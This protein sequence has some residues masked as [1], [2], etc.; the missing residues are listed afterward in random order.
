[1]SVWHS[2]YKREIIKENNIKFYS[3]R[4]Y[5]SEDIPFQVDFLKAANSASYIPDTLYYYCMN[6]A[7]SLTQSKYSNDKLERSMALYNLL[8]SK[9]RILIKNVLGRKDFSYH[10]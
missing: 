1:M 5:L 9:T 6:N 4:N 10:T 7:S 2:I 3:E 8:A